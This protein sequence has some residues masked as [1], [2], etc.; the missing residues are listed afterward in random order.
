[1]RLGM[2]LKQSSRADGDRLGCVYPLLKPL[3]AKTPAEAVRR[4]QT[5]PATCSYS[6]RSKPKVFFNLRFCYL[7]SENF[8]R[9]GRPNMRLKK[10]PKIAFVGTALGQADAVSSLN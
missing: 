2:R 5:N 3:P 7:A 10:L 9:N 4:R 6:V 1:M 8:S